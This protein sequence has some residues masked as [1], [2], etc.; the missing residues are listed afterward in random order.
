MSWHCLPPDIELAVDLLLVLGLLKAR[1][2]L[3]V[4]QE[5]Y[6]GGVVVKVRVEHWM[7]HTWCNLETP[8]IPDPMVS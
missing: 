8:K 6:M 5:L 3:V 4:V 1:L 2:L 7:T